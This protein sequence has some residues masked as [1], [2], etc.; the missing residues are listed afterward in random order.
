MSFKVGDYIAAN[1]S[2]F[3]ESLILPDEKEIQG[4]ETR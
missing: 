1:T 3:E 2:N 4:E